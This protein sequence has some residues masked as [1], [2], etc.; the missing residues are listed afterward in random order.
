[1]PYGGREAARLAF[2]VSR[3]GFT[4][5]WEYLLDS[6]IYTTPPAE[7]WSGA[8]LID[9][10]GELVGVGS[11]L[12]RDAGGGEDEVPGNV[13]VPV[14]LLKPILEGMLAAGRA[15]GPARP[16]LG[17]TTEEIQGRLFVAR[18]ATDGPAAQAGIRRGDIVLAVGEE[19]VATQA[20]LYRKVWAV[21]AAGVD[22]PLKVL[23]GASVQRLAVHS[24]DRMD[25][26]R[27]KPA[28]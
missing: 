14:D 19:P 2:V 27:R 5:S 25:Y 24:V 26:L 7:E 4:G 16:W 12:V 28:Y 3:R 8:A 22:V 23:Q 21:G 10:N 17:L 15:P 1:V 13:F 6:A 18:V 11:L 20:D 9:K